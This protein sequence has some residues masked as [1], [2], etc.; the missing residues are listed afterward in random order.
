[1]NK[2]L[3]W[4]LAW[5]I[6]TLCGCSSIHI[7]TNILGPPVSV[8]ASI[9]LNL[10]KQDQSKSVYVEVPVTSTPPGASVYI[11]DTLV[12][13]TPM[14][15]WVPFNKGWL[16][17]AKGSALILVRK[18]GYQPISARVFAVRDGHV[19][20]KPGGTPIATL[21]FQLTRE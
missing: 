8:G 15:V 20:R 21:N 9:P 14:T 12:G 10:D 1:M 11:S 13:V 17:G 3:L 19:S 7:G 16:G 18:Y 6:T 5:A 2:S 4:P